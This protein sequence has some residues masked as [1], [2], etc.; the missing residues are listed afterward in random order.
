MDA[1]AE[2]VARKSVQRAGM[3]LS[4]MRGVGEHLQMSRVLATARLLLALWVFSMSATAASDNSKPSPSPTAPPPA[5]EGKDFRE[6]DFWIGKWIVRK[7]DGTHVGNSEITRESKGCAIRENWTSLNGFSGVSI[8]YYDESDRQWHQDW[9]GGD[10][11]IL[12]LHGGLDDGAMV[13]IG[14]TKTAKGTTKNCI[15]YRMMP[16]GKMKQEWTTSDDQG[17]T[18]ETAFVGIYERQ[19]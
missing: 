19:S 8:N 16:D 18:W 11:M 14:E 5:C 10:G 15:S 4:G 9:V 7:P 6:F 3:R 2:I 13:L 12:H 1:M 17:K